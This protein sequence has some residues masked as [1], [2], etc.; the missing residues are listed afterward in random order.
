MKEHMPIVQ[1]VPSKYI[2]E[3]MNISPQWLCKIKHKLQH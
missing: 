1:K 3:F 2:A